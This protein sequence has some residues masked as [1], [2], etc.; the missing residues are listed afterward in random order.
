MAV[1]D[2][3]KIVEIMRRCPHAYLATGEGDQPWVRPVTPI[4]ED[5][6]TIWVTTSRSSRKVRQIGSNP[7]VCLAFVEQPRGESAA[8][9]TGEAVVVDAADDRRRV[10]DLAPFNL[11]KNIP[12]GSE[13]DE[14]CLLR[15]VVGRIEWREGWTSGAKVYVPA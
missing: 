10:W 3:K 5:D 14:Y 13:S 15:V 2:V 6:L 1:S 12:G 11:E 9:V 7:K 4:V 8:V